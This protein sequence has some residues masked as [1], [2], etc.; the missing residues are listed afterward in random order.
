MDTFAYFD[1]ISPAAL[2]PVT[3]TAAI[4]GTTGHYTKIDN[5][6][7][8]SSGQFT[9]F[10]RVVRKDETKTDAKSI[11]NLCPRFLS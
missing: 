3:E 11:Q 1:M 9:C 4:M 2:A 10:R 8:P 7:P 6:E 5:Y